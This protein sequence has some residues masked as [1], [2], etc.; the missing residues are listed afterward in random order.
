MQEEKLTKM[1]LYLVKNFSTMKDSLNACVTG[2]KDIVQ[3]FDKVSFDDS[4]K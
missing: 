4:N 1:Q 2:L 3:Q